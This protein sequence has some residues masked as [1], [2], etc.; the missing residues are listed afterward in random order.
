MMRKIG[1]LSD[2]HGYWDDKYLKYFVDCDEIWHAGDIGSDE[3]AAR[4]ASIHPLRAVY[5]NIDGQ[6]LRLE[7]PKIAHRIK[8]VKKDI[9]RISTIIKENAM[10]NAQ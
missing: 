3:L 5:G 8:A 2:T 10:K 4:L 7:Y 6:N 1:L 9:A